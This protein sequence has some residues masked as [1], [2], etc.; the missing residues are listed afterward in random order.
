MDVWKL[1]DYVYLVFPPS[2]NGYFDLVF[3]SVGEFISGEF[4]ANVCRGSLKS[5]LSGDI[6]PNCSK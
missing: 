2:S 4:P 3:G 6:P 1:F 5:N